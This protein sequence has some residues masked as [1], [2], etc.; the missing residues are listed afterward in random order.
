[1]T[2]TRRVNGMEAEVLF[3][4]ARVIPAAGSQDAHVG[5]GALTEA[6]GGAATLAMTA[7]IICKPHHSLHLNQAPLNKRLKCEMLTPQSI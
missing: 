2:R 7:S 1:M 5:G 4:A 6:A 3:P